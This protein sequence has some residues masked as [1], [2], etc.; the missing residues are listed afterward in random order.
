MFLPPG[1]RG[2]WLLVNP[3]FDFRIHRD[4]SSMLFGDSR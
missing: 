2:Y 4:P 3:V 1:N